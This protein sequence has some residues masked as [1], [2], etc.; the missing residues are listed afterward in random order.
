[1]LQF[2]GGSGGSERTPIHLIVVAA[3]PHR[4]DEVVLGPD[5]PA[6]AARAADVAE[7]GVEVAVLVTV[8]LEEALA[9][10]QR[11]GDELIRQDWGI[12]AGI[13]EI[14]EQLLADAVDGPRPNLVDV[15]SFK[16]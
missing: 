12:G 9:E 15:D 5:V 10:E 13:A 2:L 6:E 11:V 4:A 16:P 14:T 3:V 8:R 7:E 1:V